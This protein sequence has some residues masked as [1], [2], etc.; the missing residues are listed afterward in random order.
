M[1]DDA[2]VTGG[3]DMVAHATALARIGMAAELAGACCV[4]RLLEP[5]PSLLER[6]LARMHELR[7]RKL[8]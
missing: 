3:E 8:D 5:Y 6:Q 2:L 4:E 7:N 1:G